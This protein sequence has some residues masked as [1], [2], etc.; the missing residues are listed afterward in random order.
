MLRDDLHIVE[1]L[2]YFLFQLLLAYECLSWASWQANWCLFG[3]IS[4]S[5]GTS[6]W[7]D[8]RLFLDNRVYLG[9]SIYCL[10]VNSLSCLLLDFLLFFEMV[11]IGNHKVLLRLFNPFELALDDWVR[12]VFMATCSFHAVD[13][14]GVNHL[15]LCSG[16]DDR[17]SD[18]LLIVLLRFFSVLYHFL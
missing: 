8:R 12:H 16:S 3:K 15:L 1:Q 13:I 4:D 6:F 14:E 17:L 11:A 18:W 7:H 5:K 9:K 10:I 2:H